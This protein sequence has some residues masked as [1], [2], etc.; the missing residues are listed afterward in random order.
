MRALILKPRVYVYN[1]LMQIY[2]KAYRM[3]GNAYWKLFGGILLALLWSAVGTLLLCTMIGFPLS[4]K[5]Y[6]FA[7]ISYKPFGHSVTV[8]PGKNLPLALIWAL[9][10]GAV[11]CFICLTGAFVSCATVIGIPAVCQWLKIG[12]LGL[13]PFSSYVD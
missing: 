6:K 1:Y 10:L 4:L 8:V 13:F 9:T 5:C 3:L 2:R 12:R 11:M 7:Y